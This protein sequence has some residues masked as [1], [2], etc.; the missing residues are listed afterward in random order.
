[1]VGGDSKNQGVIKHLNKLIGTNLVVHKNSH[2]FGALGAASLLL[3]EINT[4]E[5][6]KITSV[7]DII[8]NKKQKAKYFYKP[9]KL[10][11]SKYPDFSSMK[12]YKYQSGNKFLTPV[13]IDI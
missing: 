4:V 8:R 10:K 7:N 1:M 3:N 5:Y 11:L 12:K 6:N 13:E 9:L 2:L